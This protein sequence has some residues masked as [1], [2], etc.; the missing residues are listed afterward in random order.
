MS[1]RDAI[2][3]EAQTWLGTPWRHEAEIK[4]EGGGVDCGHFLRAAYVGAGIVP[5]FPIDPYPRDWHLNQRGERFLAYV[6]SWLDR[7]DDPLPGDVAVFRF[8]RCFS[9]GAI[10]V[11]WPTVIHS[12]L[13][14]RAVS[15]ENAALGE[16]AVQRNGNPRACRFYTYAR[17]VTP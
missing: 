1:W 9:H 8:G 10:V 2:I 4:G 3:T 5:S 14:A 17:R 6:E 7:T 11:S 15:Y 16:L 13:P 12:Y